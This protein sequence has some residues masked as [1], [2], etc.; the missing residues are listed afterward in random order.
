MSDGE[1]I[2]LQ[3]ASKSTPFDP[4]YLGLL[5]RKGWLFGVKKNGRWYTT[6]HDVSQY[7]KNS[8]RV[9]ISNEELPIKFFL[10]QI[11]VGLFLFVAVLF[12]F[13]MFLDTSFF[14]G[15]RGESSKI[16]TERVWSASG[17][18]PVGISDGEYI[19]SAVS[20]R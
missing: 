14:K 4:N 20:N 17:K 12:L 7:M 19:S 1:Y 15:T 11:G 6:K 9:N 3:E 5:I 16:S 10:L 13:S 18:S 8:A 2:S